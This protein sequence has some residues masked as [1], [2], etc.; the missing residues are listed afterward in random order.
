MYSRVGLPD[1][2]ENL[3]RRKFNEL[4]VRREGDAVF[5]VRE[6]FV[7]ADSFAGDIGPAATQP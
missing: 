3:E 1:S 5:A 2:R 4:S 6:R 7:I